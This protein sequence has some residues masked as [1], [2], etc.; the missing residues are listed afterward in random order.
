VATSRSATETAYVLFLFLS[1]PRRI[2]VGALGI[3][4]F[5]PGLYFYVGSGGR[6]PARRIARHARPRKN[7]FWHIDYLTAHARV[8]GAMVFEASRSLECH[9]AVALEGAFTPVPRFGSS[10]CSCTS[11]LFRVP[12]R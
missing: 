2:R 11:H 7:K 1:K 6:S 12:R 9:I 10:D 8:L 3:I 4:G 5:E